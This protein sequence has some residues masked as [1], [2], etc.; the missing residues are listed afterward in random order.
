MG[1]TTILSHINPMPKGPQGQLPPRWW[2]LFLLVIALTVTACAVT[3]PPLPSD[4]V[5]DAQAA[6][7]IGQETCLAKEALRHARQE[8]DW[9]AKFSHG[10][11]RTWEGDE[12][13]LCQSFGTNINAATGKSDGSCSICVT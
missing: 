1:A 5:Q 11:W 2:A 9:H 4:V 8:R 3:D 6:I 7:R 12:A 10:V 13:G